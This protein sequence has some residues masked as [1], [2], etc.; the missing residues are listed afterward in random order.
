[1]I[2]PRDR[3]RRDWPAGLR[4]PRP[5]YFTWRHPDGKEMAIGRVSLA[6]AKDEARAANEYVQAQRPSLLERLTGASNTVAQLLERMPVPDNKNTAKSVRSLDKKILEALGPIPCHALTV[7]HC[8]DLIE[9]E[10]EAGRERT[11][12]ALR[13][14]L[15]AVCKRGQ[16]IGWLEFNPAEPTQTREVKTRRERLSLE[17]FNAILEKAPQVNEWLHGAM[18]LALLTGQDRSTLSQLER[19]GIGTEFLTVTR[20]KTNVTIEIPLRLRLEAVGMTVSDALTACRSNVVSKY[21]F[22]IHHGKGYGNAPLGSSIHPDRMS[23]AFAEARELAGI[24]GDNPPTWHEIRSLSKRLYKDQGGVDTKALL[25]HKTE[26][27]S[28][29]YA[30]PRGSAPIRVAYS[31][32]VTHTPKVTS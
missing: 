16:Q 31:P 2:R 3:R 17:Q 5:G 12:Q 9:G 11:S 8:A 26:R 25:G 13:S 30:D 21:R 7:K 14:R 27:M 22:V 19:T 28:D 6:Q 1:M 15:D 24:A 18:L 20:G 10:I 4:E 29:M 23:H 32:Q